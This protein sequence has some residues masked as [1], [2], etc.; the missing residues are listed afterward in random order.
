MVRTNS[1]SSGNEASDTAVAPGEHTATPDSIRRGNTSRATFDESG[2]MRASMPSSL[3]RASTDPTA[4][5]ASAPSSATTNSTGRPSTPPASLMMRTAAL[6]TATSGSPKVAPSPDWGTSRPKRNTPSSSGW[7]T[8]V[9]N[10]GVLSG[11]DD[12]SLV[13]Q[14][15]AEMATAATTRRRITSGAPNRGGP[16]RPP[17]RPRS[18]RGCPTPWPRP[19]P[20]GTAPRRTARRRNR[21]RWA[22]RCSW[23]RW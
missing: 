14:A 22:C 7:G 2:P 21:D 4:V 15:T 6:A 17:A 3:T 5:V 12:D 16:S 23:R 20:V 10:C 18:D 1:S 13:E 8:V 9:E 11:V 19:T